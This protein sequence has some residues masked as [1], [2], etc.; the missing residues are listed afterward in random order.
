M[1]NAEAVWAGVFWTVTG[2]TLLCV[3]VFVP[4]RE[5]ASPG[6][7]Y[8]LAGLALIALGRGVEKFRG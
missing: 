8:Y 5:G 3:T 4:A 6:G 1:R 2:L 7:K